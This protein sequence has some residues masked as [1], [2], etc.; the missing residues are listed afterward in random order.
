MN[1]IEAPQELTGTLQGAYR[2]P[3]EELHL[4]RPLRK[5]VIFGEASISH[6]VWLAERDPVAHYFFYSVS[7]TV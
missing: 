3:T 1:S 7:N 2:N 6:K 4:S 5:C